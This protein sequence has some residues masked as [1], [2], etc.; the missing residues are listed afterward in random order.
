[1]KDIL[2]SF[3]FTILEVSKAALIHVFSFLIEQFS[4][5]NPSISVTL[6]LSHTHFLSLSLTHTHTFSL[7]LSLSLS[8]TFSLSLSLSPSLSRFL[9]SSLS[10]P[11]LTYSLAP[12]IYFC[13]SL[14]ISLSFRIRFR[15]GSIVW[16]QLS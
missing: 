4:F 14:F 3:L 10:L 2:T 8:H 5:F 15:I 9:S 13:N 6:S 7:S 1:M 16:D 12:C 11:F